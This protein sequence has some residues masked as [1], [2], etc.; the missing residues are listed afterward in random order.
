MKNREEADLVRGSTRW[1]SQLDINVG[2]RKIFLLFA[3][4]SSLVVILCIWSS[5]ASSIALVSA[6]LLITDAKI[7]NHDRSFYGSVF[8]DDGAIQSVTED[9]LDSPMQNLPHGTRIINASG[10]LLMP[11]GIDPHTHLDMPFMGTTTAD[12]FTSGQEAAVA[13]GTT[14]HI[15]FALPINHDLAL[16]FD[17]WMKKAKS[18]AVIDYG[19]HMAVTRWDNKTSSDMAALASKGVN[20]FKFFMA[21]KGALQV[22]DEELIEGFQRSKEVGALPM[23]HCENGDGVVYGQKKMIAQGITAPYGHSLSRPAF[24]EGEAT[25]RAI[26]LARLVE[27]PL[28]IVHVMSKDALDEVT[29]AKK[30]GQVVYGEPVASGL[31]LSESALFNPDFDFAAAHVMSPPIRSRMDGEALKEGLAEGFLDL[32]ATDHAVFTKEQKAR[33]KEDFRLIPN[34]CNGIE[35]R[36]HVVW[37]EMVNSGLMDESDYVRIT[38]TSA[39]KIFNVYPRKGLI[40]VG[41]DADLILLDPKLEHT[42]SASTHHSK[43]DSSVYEGRKIRGKV[44]MTISQGKVLWENGRLHTRP[45]EGRFTPMPPIHRCALT[46]TGSAEIDFKKGPLGCGAHASVKPKPNNKLSGSAAADQVKV[47]EYDFKL[48]L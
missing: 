3:M 29:R 46:G 5:R 27:T 45:G 12:D 39:A 6:P 48:E 43:I 21:Y 34:G 18:K 1:L 4:I 40:A 36:M 25:S 31:A 41:S 14:F 23:V 42:L 16:G 11:G 2:N 30:A 47:D 24:L 44:T 15:D 28:Y 8:I 20:S 10:L 22:T 26:R 32:V 33:G 37:D 7:V 38:S 19:F 9:G 35:E 17:A 13:G